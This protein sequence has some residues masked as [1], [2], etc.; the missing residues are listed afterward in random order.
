MVEAYLQDSLKSETDS[1]LTI[2]NQAEERLTHVA[3]IPATKAHLK[4]ITY[5]TFIRSLNT[6]IH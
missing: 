2:M 3:L 6:Y 5:E 4:W 1:Y